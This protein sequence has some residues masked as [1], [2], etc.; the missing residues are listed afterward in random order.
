[1]IKTVGVVTLSAVVAFVLSELG[2]R[3]K[4][5]FTAVCMVLLSSLILG[6]MGRLIGETVGF[7]ELSG[8]SDVALCAVKIIGIGYIFGICSDI[9]AE[10]G[11]GAL[12]RGL[13][14]AGKV[15]VLLLVLPY[16][17]DIIELGLGLIK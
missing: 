13:I 10:L 14:S 2:F 17:K 6:G 1:M 9:V 16:F 11:E 5:I 12:A 7:A 8:V 15:E 4:R 3:G